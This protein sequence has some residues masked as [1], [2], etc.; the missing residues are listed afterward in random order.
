MIAVLLEIAGV[1]CLILLNGLFVAA[2]FAIVKVRSTQIE[3]LLK[4]GHSRARL[5]EHVIN[6]LDQYISTT[7]LGITV[8]NLALGWLG[9]PLVAGL[10][11]PVMGLVGFTGR[12]VVGTVA[13]VLAFGLITFLQIVIGE[14]APKHLAIRR[15][16]RIALSLVRPL[17]AF[18]LVFRPFIW[19]L[20][21]S[22]HAFLRFLGIQPARE[23]DI[24]HSEEELRLLLGKGKMFSSTGKNILLN[25]MEMHKR[26]VREIMVPRTGVVFLS[27]GKSM[28]ENIT[29]A[30]ESQFTRFPLCEA[31]LDNVLG[32]VHM[33]DLFRLKDLH[34]SGILSI[35]LETGDRT[36]VSGAI[37]DAK[38]GQLVGATT[39]GTGTVLEEFPLPDQSAMLLATQ[40]WLTPKGRTIWHKGIAP[41][42][43]VPLASGVSPL[44]PSAEKSMTATQVQ[45]TEGKVEAQR[46]LLAAA[47]SAVERDPDDQR[48]RD[49]VRAQARTPVSTVVRLDLADPG[50]QRPVQ[51]TRRPALLRG[52]GGCF[53]GA[54]SPCR[55]VAGGRVRDRRSAH[56]GRD[57]RR[58]RRVGSSVPAHPR[59]AAQPPGLP[60]GRR[61]SIA[62]IGWRR[63][64]IR[65]FR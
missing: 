62:R 41:D 5:V 35:D 11:E 32:M 33:K 31:D 55:D 42:Q 6:H 46:G 1:A 50:E 51:A 19:L 45:S 12:A 56:G 8:T 60:P 17:N 58:D 24:A 53:V 25:A 59:S 37:Q 28:E 2:E 3:P 21:V 65:R 29:L 54:Q 49:T 22:A 64:W 7:Q 38:R 63:P 9:E 39:F 52:Q 16:Q 43:A 13:L 36:L 4:S 18:F 30:I 40:E 48:S 23:G 14:L 57:R 20:N 61:R 26:S 44:F 10:I 47:R 34:G 27:T 15:P